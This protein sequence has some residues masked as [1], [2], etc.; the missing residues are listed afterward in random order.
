MRK[1]KR[2]NHNAENVHHIVAGVY[3]YGDPTEIRK[4]AY[5]GATLLVMSPTL[6][7]GKD[8]EQLKRELWRHRRRTKPLKSEKELHTSF[9]LPPPTSRADGVQPP[10]TWLFF[11]R[12]TQEFGKGDS[13]KEW[14][15]WN[16]RMA[17]SKYKTDSSTPTL[18]N[19]HHLRA[20]PRTLLKEF[21]RLPEKTQLHWRN[22]IN[23]AT[24]EFN[25]KLQNLKS[26]I[27]RKPT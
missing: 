8:V 21:Y 10:H 6:M 9:G 18:L 1:L 15:E 27:P 11:T 2:L 7:K 17:I 25:G 4:R 23:E 5:I 26:G 20:R 12:L 14:V 13:V 22:C 24:T 16:E 19:K 3:F